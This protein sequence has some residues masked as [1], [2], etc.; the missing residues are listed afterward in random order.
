MFARHPGTLGKL[1]VVSSAVLAFWAVSLAAIPAHAF[2]LDF[3]W[4]SAMEA[5]TDDLKALGE[6]DPAGKKK[7]R[8][9]E[10]IDREIDRL[11]GKAADK[12]ERGMWKV[13]EKTWKR[14]EKMK[15]L[16][17]T[18]KKLGKRWAPAAKMGTR[19]S[20]H[21]GTALTVWDFGYAVGDKLIA[22]KVVS[23]IERRFK[24]KWKKQEEALRRDI[25]HS[26]RLGEQRRQ[27]KKDVLDVLA[28]GHALRQLREDKQGPWATT[29]DPWGEDSKGA[30]AAPRG[31]GTPA[32]R[33]DPWAEDDPWAAESSDVRL[34]RPVAAPAPAPPAVLKETE[35]GSSNYERALNSLQGG[36]TQSAGYEQ[37]L[38]K[39][40]ADRRAERVRREAETEA[41]RRET[42]R[43]AQRAE[44][45]QTGADARSGGESTKT[46]GDGTCGSAPACRKYIRH[47]EQ[48]LAETNHIRPTSMTDGAL[49]TGFVVRSTL[50]CMRKC[51]PYETPSCKTVVLTAVSELEN[52]YRSAMENARASSADSSYVDDFDRDP[53]VSRFVRNHGIR[54]SGSSLDSSC[55]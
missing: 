19:L 30:N 40:E 26:R 34:A 10:R 9:Q 3:S 55:P 16:G 4:E 42:A 11:A 36:G 13:G 43:L 27:H 37:A 53:T 6:E 25:A 12:A 54:V 48:V 46:A 2:G 44:E 31:A 8:G 22:P 21:V 17:P 32:V 24:N 38:E 28:V 33:K 23:A 15:T 1:T 18:M 49:L 50:G 29:D 7:S 35:T 47:G 41:A 52:T 39:L 51:L 45:Q 20:P 14:L 5:A